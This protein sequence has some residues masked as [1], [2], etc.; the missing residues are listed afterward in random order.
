MAD[1]F[2]T[3]YLF[4]YQEFIEMCN[5]KFPK[6]IGTKLPISINGSGEECETYQELEQRQ[7]NSYL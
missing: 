5:K 1:F 3:V 6:S 7:V 4:I 2:D